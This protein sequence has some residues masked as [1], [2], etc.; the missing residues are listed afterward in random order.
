MD[1]K[2]GNHINFLGMALLLFYAFSFAPS[3]HVHHHHHHDCE[4][5]AF[6]DADSCEKAIYYGIP[7]EHDQHISKTPEKCWLCDHYTITPQILVEAQ[8]VLTQSNLYVANFFWCERYLSIELTGTAN[9][10]P[11]FFA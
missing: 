8:S 9:K 4:I 5:V 7:D 3:L 2:K 6:S 11:P 1:L 10:D